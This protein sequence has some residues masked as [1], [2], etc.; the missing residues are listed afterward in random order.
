MDFVEQ[1]PHSRI[2][3]VLGPHMGKTKFVQWNV[4]TNDI[5]LRWDDAKSRISSAL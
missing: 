3:R 4:S 5:P 2:M 1:I